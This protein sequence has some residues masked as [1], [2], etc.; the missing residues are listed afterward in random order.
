VPSYCRR[1]STAEQLFCK[2]QVIGSIPFA[3][4]LISSAPTDCSRRPTHGEPD[5][6]FDSKPVSF[7]GLR[8]RVRVPLAVAPTS[9]ETGTIEL[10]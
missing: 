9:T 4:S 1:S 8:G 7:G 10:P 3:G 5:L 6:R 2:Q